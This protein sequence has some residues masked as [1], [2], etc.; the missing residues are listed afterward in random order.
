MLPDGTSDRLSLRCSRTVRALSWIAAA[1]CGG[2]AISFAVAGGKDAATALV[3]LA[4]AICFAVAPLGNVVL[5][6]DG[7]TGTFMRGRVIRWSDIERFHVIS[8]YPFAG[9]TWVAYTFTPEHV[10]RTGQARR[11]PLARG[12]PKGGMLAYNSY[13]TSAEAAATTL[14][15]WR[16]R[17][18]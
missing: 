14:D 5:T 11:L 3:F 2:V 12:L 1:V 7:F 17:F 10:A 16:Q 13:G 8:G 4:F 18:T 6:S 15:A 9:M